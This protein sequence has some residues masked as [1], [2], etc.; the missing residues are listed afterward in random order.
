MRILIFLAAFLLASCVNNYKKFYQG[1]ALPETTLERFENFVGIPEIRSG[2]TPTND[3]RLMIKEGYYPIGQSSF[4]GPDS[5]FTDTLDVAK[6]NGASKITVYKK[7]RNTRSGAVPIN[8]PTTQN[9]FHSGS[10]IGNM[11]SAT[12]SGTSTSFGTAT[13]LVPYSTDIYEQTA[14]YWRRLR[15]G[16]FGI[17][18]SELSDKERKEL[19]SNKGVK[20]M[21]LRNGSAAFDNDV[22]IGDIIIEV[23]GTRLNSLK[24]AVEL[25][26]NSYGKT[27]SLLIRRDGKL[28]KKEFF[29]PNLEKRK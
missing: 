25:V 4:Y 6:E 10:I 28:I 2:S 9:T 1:S 7:F 3:Q 5:P 14:I 24:Q 26:L 29:V 8:M 11:S 12:Y 21:N 19:G 17:Q 22:L 27:N 18:F 20:V 16:G 13:T 15:R 23:N